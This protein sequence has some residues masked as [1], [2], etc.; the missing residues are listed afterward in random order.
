MENGQVINTISE[1]GTSDCKDWSNGL[2]R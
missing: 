1:F 2:R